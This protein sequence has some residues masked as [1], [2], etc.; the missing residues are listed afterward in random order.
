MRF[1]MPDGRKYSGGE[2]ARAYT[3]HRPGF[4]AL[5]Q[6]GEGR[7]RRAGVRR[8]AYQDTR[9]LRHSLESWALEEPPGPP[10]PDPDADRDPFDSVV[11]LALRLGATG[12]AI[13]LY[14]PGGAVRVVAERAQDPA[15]AALM[16]ALSGP[17]DEDD[18]P[19]PGP[20]TTV[21]TIPLRDEGRVGG[22]MVCARR[23]DP[24]WFTAENVRSLERLALLALVACQNRVLQLSA[25]N[26][27]A[28]K[29][30]FLAVMSHELRTPLTAII[31]YGDLLEQGIGG[32]L[33]E[34]QQAR[35]RGIKASAWRLLE[36]INEILA[37]S[38][39]ESGTDAV[40]HESVS[41]AALLDEVRGPVEGVARQ[42]G[43][44]LRIRMEGRDDVVT[45][46]AKVLAIL[47]N[48]LSN[49]LKFTHE[50]EVFVRIHVNGAGLAITVADTGVG[51]SADQVEAMFQ[52]FWQAEPAA[53]RTVGGAGLGLAVVQRAVR[54]LDGRLDVDSEPGMG[55]T[56]TV[57]IPL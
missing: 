38:H 44:R 30:N 39:M 46:R 28:A 36:L 41:L 24:S 29:A 17:G 13:W 22:A 52:P 50:G 9:A 31:G 57:T 25:R 7:E 6:L 56:F 47:R 11:R 49:A 15:T 2:P 45:D 20:S 19:E 27:T 35:A 40:R 12:S 55:S 54:L 43:L 51:M 5:D 42:A 48:L 21:V 37:F 18:E 4:R 3:R 16:R 33:T 10:G 32:A 8:S 53:T 14:E 23:G 26:A 34:D 1:S